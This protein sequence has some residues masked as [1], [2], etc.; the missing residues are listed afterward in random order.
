MAAG[1]ESS[2]GC[3]AG[4][5]SAPV[6]TARPMQHPRVTRGSSRAISRAATTQRY[7]MD[8]ESDDS[9]TLLEMNVPPAVITLFGGPADG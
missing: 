5:W 9:F 2:G 7:D 8:T 3:P 6:A 1:D 4:R